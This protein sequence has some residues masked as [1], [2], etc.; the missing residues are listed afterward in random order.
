VAD[1]LLSAALERIP[2]QL[3]AAAESPPAGRESPQTVGDEQEKVAPRPTT[4]G[5]QESRW[6]R[7][8]RRVFG[9]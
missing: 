8:R 3:E 1:R 9:G 6:R 5:P 4:S 7:L 2:L